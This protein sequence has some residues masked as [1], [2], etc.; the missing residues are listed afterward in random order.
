M[1]AVA[2]AAG[3]VGGDGA[4]VAV[5]PGVPLEVHCV[6]RL[7]RDVLVAW[8]SALVARDVVAAVLLRR[9]EAVVLVVGHPAS[10]VGD[11]A[12]DPVGGGTS[13]FLTTSGHLLDETVCRDGGDGGNG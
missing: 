11:I 2:V 8:G 5:R 9:N 10:L 13:V 12:V 6:A 1:S 4:L 3:H 7:D